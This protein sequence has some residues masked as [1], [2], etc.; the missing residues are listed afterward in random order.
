MAVG[1]VP[2]MRRA[3]ALLTA[4]GAVAAIA[5]LAPHDQPLPVEGRRIEATRL[6]SE[7]MSGASAVGGPFTLQ[8]ASGK[9]VGLSDFRG[10]VVL[11]YFGY[12][13]CPDV[14]PSDL[15]AIG[16]CVN[17][18]GAAGDEVQPI[19]VT[20]DPERDRGQALRDYA[21]QGFGRCSVDFEAFNVEA[22]TFWLK[23]FDP[24]CLSV[25]RV[26]ERVA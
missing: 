4:I 7:L 14:C 9:R 18:L 25:T 21:A 6:M 13:F 15:A 23:Y 3:A 11:L 26:P 19:F 20:L 8:D 12:M 16:Q 2:S 10:K 17:A 22:A 24:V 5:L 1:A